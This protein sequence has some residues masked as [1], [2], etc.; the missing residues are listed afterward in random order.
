MSHS[1]FGMLEH[2]LRILHSLL[3]LCFFL[4]S[5]NSY[6][7]DNDTMTQYNVVIEEPAQIIS[8]LKTIKLHR[9]Y[10][11]PQIE[12]FAILIDWFACLIYSKG[13]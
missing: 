2:L 13:C 5:F 7:D 8:D 6:A 9:T 10:F 11:N 3:I 4:F 12:T 1:D